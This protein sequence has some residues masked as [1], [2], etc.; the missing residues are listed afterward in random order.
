[1]TP[2]QIKLVQSSFQ[3]V[4]PIADTAADIFYD[5]LFEIAPE[6][7][8]LFPDDMKEQKKKLLKMLAGA[9]NGLDRVE[10]VVPV[11]QGLGV[12]HAGY[13]VK[14]EQYDTVGA[15]LL[16]TL[17]KGLGDDFTPEVEEAWTECY[18]L[19]AGVMKEA[20]AQVAA[21]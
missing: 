2:E 15:A 12:R 6:V 5:R 18:S 20:Q 4:L 13:N 10:E 9:V 8:S 14:L 17:G 21:A 16:Y 7:R 19:V 1:M 3:K 11:L